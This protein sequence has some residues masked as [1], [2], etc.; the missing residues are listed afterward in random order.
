MGIEDRAPDNT[1]ET[2]KSPTETKEKFSPDEQKLIDEYSKSKI[3]IANQ[4]ID[5]S[6]MEA[7]TKKVSYESWRSAFFEQNYKT[8]SKNPDK[9]PSLYPLL[10]TRLQNNKIAIKKMFEENFNEQKKTFT[11]EETD[12]ANIVYNSYEM[13]S[14]LQQNPEKKMYMARTEYN[15]LFVANILERIDQKNWEKFTKLNN[16]V[17]RVVNELFYAADNDIQKSNTTDKTKERLNTINWL[18]T[19]L[20]DNNPYL[21]ESYSSIHSQTKEHIQTL[22]AIQWNEMVNQINFNILQQEKN[23]KSL[24]NFLKI[25]EDKHQDP[26]ILKDA[27]IIIKPVLTNVYSDWLDT[28]SKAKEEQDPLQQIILYMSAQEQFKQISM[29]KETSW[30]DFSLFDEELET[31]CTISKEMENEIKNIFSNNEMLPLLYDA[32]Y[33]TYQEALKE[34]DKDLKREKYETAKRY[35]EA[36]IEQKTGKVSSKMNELIQKTEIKIKN[37][38]MYLT[39]V[40]GTNITIE[41]INIADLPIEWWPSPFPKDNNDPF[42]LYVGENKQQFDKIEIFNISWQLVALYE[43][44]KD[45]FSTPDTQSKLHQNYENP[46][47]FD[48]PLQERSLAAG[49]YIF[50]ISSKTTTISK[51]EKF[52]VV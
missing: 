22:A 38:N 48:L 9:Y 45:V 11:W 1:P 34:A 15:N 13:Q 2:I 29:T 10:Q 35:F 49:A 14:W 42:H 44:N 51:S 46:V 33:K 43:I 27:V 23:K 6:N 31:F 52:V 30:I 24:D 32:W 41:N 7:E 26:T 28:Y 3:L 39:P 25:T 19:S 36:I 17:H 21:Y 12:F 40:E 18:L 47:Q 50:R 8:I 5:P 20:S 4:K 16:I 37:I